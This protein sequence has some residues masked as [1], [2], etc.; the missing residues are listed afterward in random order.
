MKEKYSAFVVFEKDPAYAGRQHYDN[1]YIIGPNDYIHRYLIPTTP[2]IINQIT[3]LE[4]QRVFH[5]S[6]LPRA[7]SLR[8]DIID[9]DKFIKPFGNR[10]VFVA[11]IDSASETFQAEFGF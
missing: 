2:E 1:C 5:I 8:K 10:T 6:S 3:L 4:I 9:D 11:L 7:I